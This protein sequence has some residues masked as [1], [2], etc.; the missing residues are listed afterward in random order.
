VQ[1]LLDTQVFLW[2]LAEPDRLGR[3]IGS[4]EDPNNELLLSAASSW[5]IAIKIQLGR[6]DLPDDPKRYVPDRMRAIGAE[7]LPI[8]HNHALA[9][10]ELPPLHRDPFDRM[11]VAQARDLRLTIVT[12]DVQIARYEVETLLV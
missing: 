11:L 5:E 10:S 6:L 3:H 2:L 8:E 9:V 4:L 1:L 12:A 7:P